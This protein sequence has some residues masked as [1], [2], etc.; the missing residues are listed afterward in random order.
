MAAVLIREAVKAQHNNTFHKNENDVVLSLNYTTGY[1][2][3]K[4]GRAGINY[5]VLPSVTLFH[6][7]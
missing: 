6:L 3:D 5:S 4:Q 7:L 2:Q 1:Q